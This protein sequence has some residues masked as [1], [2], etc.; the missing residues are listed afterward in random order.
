[1]G[2][3]VSHK[4][5]FVPG[6]VSKLGG[7]SWKLQLTFHLGF[8]PYIYNHNHLREVDLNKMISRAYCVANLPTNHQ[9]P[10]LGLAGWPGDRD[11]EL[12]SPEEAGEAWAA[13]G[14]LDRRK[15]TNLVLRPDVGQKGVGSTTWCLTKTL[16][17]TASILTLEDFLTCLI[18]SFGWK[19]SVAPAFLTVGFLPFG[20]PVRADPVNAW[21]RR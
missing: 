18:G 9:K 7:S 2:L 10:S 1:M 11:Q 5:F 3:R 13:N 6:M 12:A 19:T 4:A 21:L 17:K 8:L 14:P 15:T 20:P 16:E